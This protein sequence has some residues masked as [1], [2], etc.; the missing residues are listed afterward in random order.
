MCS[1]LR[2]E[3]WLMWFAYPFVVLS[4]VGHAQNPAFSPNTQIFALGS[5]EIAFGCFLSL[6]LVV[7]N[8]PQLWCI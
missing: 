7:Q 8:L 6:S 1:G 5:S 2:L 3:G 4:G